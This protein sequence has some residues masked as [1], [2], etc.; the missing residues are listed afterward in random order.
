[1]TTTQEWIEKQRHYLELEREA[2]RLQLMEKLTTLTSQ[3]CQEIGISLLLLDIESSC[4]SLYGRVKHK[5]IRKDQQPLPIHSFKVGDEAELFEY[6]KA[7]SKEE[8][9]AITGI[10][11]KVTSMYI[12]LISDESDGVCLFLF[13]HL[14]SSFSSLF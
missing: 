14:F 3:E 10:I 5:I 1:M 2:E 7:T 6:K 11:S 9:V 13:L 12:E 4:V 8:T